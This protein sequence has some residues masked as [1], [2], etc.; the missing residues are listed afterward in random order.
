MSAGSK[1][2]RVAGAQSVEEVK[3]VKEV[4]EVRVWRWKETSSRR[5]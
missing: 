2:G 4:D 3:E 5:N 1:G